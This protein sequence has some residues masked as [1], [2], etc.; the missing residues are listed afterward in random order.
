MLTSITNN[1]H[2][3]SYYLCSVPHCSADYYPTLYYAT[4]IP[5]LLSNYALRHKI[6]TSPK[7][8]TVLWNKNKIRKMYSLESFQSCSSCNIIVAMSASWFVEHHGSTVD[9]YITLTQKGQAMQKL[10]P[11]SR[12]WHVHCC[13]PTMTLLLLCP[14]NN[15][16]FHNSKVFL[17]SPW[18]MRDT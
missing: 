10:Y 11:Q 3:M 7:E 12:F 15:L 6:W 5:C 16:G 8:Q 14:N 13:E 17:Q 2:H 1:V 9:L 18:D 4:T